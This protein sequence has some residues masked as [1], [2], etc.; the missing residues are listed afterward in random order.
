VTTGFDVTDGVVVSTTI[1]EP[2]SHVFIGQETVKVLVFGVWGTKTVSVSVPA[3]WV[4]ELGL[5]VEDDVEDSTAPTLASL[6][7]EVGVHGGWIRYEELASLFRFNV[8][9]S[10]ALSTELVEAVGLDTGKVC[11][12]DASMGGNGSSSSGDGKLV[13][14]VCSLFVRESTCQADEVTVGVVFGHLA[15][16]FRAPV[17]IPL[18]APIRPALLVATV[19]VGTESRG[20]GNAKSVKAALL[21]A[22]VDVDI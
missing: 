8:L 7:H 11:K 6:I 3:T 13:E 18:G 4:S 9:T 15:E 5:K 20:S 19:L 16:N 1:L 14:R 10:F 21:A 2:P 17:A 22:V 12:I